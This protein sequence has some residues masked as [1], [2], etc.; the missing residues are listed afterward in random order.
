MVTQF[1]YISRRQI[2]FMLVRRLRADAAYELGKSLSHKFNSSHQLAYCF[3]SLFIYNINNGKSGSVGKLTHRASSLFKYKQKWDYPIFISK[4]KNM[5]SGNQLLSSF[6]K[7]VCDIIR[8][9]IV[10]QEVFD[11]DWQN[12]KV[13]ESLPDLMIR[14]DWSATE[15]GFDFWETL[16][17]RIEKIWDE[18]EESGRIIVAEA[19]Q[20]S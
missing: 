6:P 18:A 12:E 15:H 3:S 17:V 10:R 11:G 4:T 16:F 2:P 19:A 20:E 14:V 1:S 5:Y 7:D 13:F 9:E 8:K